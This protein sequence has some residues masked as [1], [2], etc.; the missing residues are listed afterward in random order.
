MLPSHPGKRY[1]PLSCLLLSL[2]LSSKL[3][4]RELQ[5]PQVGQRSIADACQAPARNVPRGAQAQ[6]AEG[7]GSRGTWKAVSKHVK[8]GH[9]RILG[10]LEDEKVREAT[11]MK[12]EM[13]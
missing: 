9:E 2:L 8:E 7:L 3:F 5:A 4:L 1:L 11:C 10:M 6:H 13:K 12:T